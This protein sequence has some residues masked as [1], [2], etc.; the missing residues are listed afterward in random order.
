MIFVRVLFRNQVFSSGDEIV[1]DVLLLVQHACSMPVFSELG[2]PAQV[3]HGIDSAVF[4]PKIGAPVEDRSDADIEASV[5]REQRRIF[6]VLLKPFFV[7]HEHGDARAILRVVPDLVDLIG[8]GLDRR[9]FHLAPE[10]SLVIVQIVTEDGGRHSERLETK[11]CFILV[12]L[13][14][15][16]ENSTDRRQG[17][18]VELLALD[19]EELELGAGIVLVLREKLS[20]EY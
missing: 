4:Q 11:E 2:A 10:G 3:C 15:R 9:R 18:V 19:V 1:K 16:C 20:A 5:A 17:N 7:D 12:P 13:A 6:G 8:R 14:T